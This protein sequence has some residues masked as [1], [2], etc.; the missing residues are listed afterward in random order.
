MTKAVLLD[1]TQTLANSTDGFRAAEKQ[2]EIWIV[3]DLGLSSWDDFIAGY[4]ELR[5][6]FNDR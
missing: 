2:V 6:Q 1:F 5:R 3:A 4:R